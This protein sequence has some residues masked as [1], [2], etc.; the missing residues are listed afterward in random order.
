MGFPEVVINRFLPSSI[1]SIDINIASLTDNRLEIF[2]KYDVSKERDEQKMHWI[3]ITI[4]N[5]FRCIDI[6]LFDMSNI[7]LD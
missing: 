1:S 2:F 7:H 5:R 4:S 3:F 6:L